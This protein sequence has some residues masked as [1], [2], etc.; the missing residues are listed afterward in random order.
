MKNKTH[1]KGHFYVPCNPFAGITR[2]KYEGIISARNLGH[3]LTYIL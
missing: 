2:I 3:P 1:K